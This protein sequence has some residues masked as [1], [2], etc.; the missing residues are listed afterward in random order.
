MVSGLG[1]TD[2]RRDLRVGASHGL[3]ATI[4]SDLLDMAGFAADTSPDYGRRRLFPRHSR[5]VTP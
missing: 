4:L 1:R 5:G 3:P 2:G